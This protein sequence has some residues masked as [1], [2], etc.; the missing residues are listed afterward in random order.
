MS[1]ALTLMAKDVLLSP[2][3]DWNHNLNELGNKV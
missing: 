2:P 1:N 3:G